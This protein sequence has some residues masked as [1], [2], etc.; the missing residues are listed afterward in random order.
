LKGD[1]CYQVY[2]GYGLTIGEKVLM[3]I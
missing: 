1:I 2:A 3:H